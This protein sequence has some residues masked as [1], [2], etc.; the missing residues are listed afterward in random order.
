MMGKDLQMG[1]RNLS[2]QFD[3]S[4]M[5]CCHFGRTVQRCKYF[6]THTKANCKSE[7]LSV[8]GIMKKA[9]STH[10]RLVSMVKTLGVPTTTISSST[11]LSL[12]TE[13][14]RR[15]QMLQ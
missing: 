7:R 4:A 15:G 10:L 1:R 5:F 2:L 14:V 11:S 9:K 6:Y 12:K 8:A 13:V 3:K